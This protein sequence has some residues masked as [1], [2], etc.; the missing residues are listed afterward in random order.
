MTRKNLQLR[1]NLQPRPARRREKKLRRA[2]LADP[3]CQNLLRRRGH[4]DQHYVWLPPTPCTHHGHTYSVNGYRMVLC[5]CCARRL[6][7]ETGCKIRKV[8]ALT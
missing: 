5:V 1:L 2:G 8:R 7:R 6:I 3:V 4:V